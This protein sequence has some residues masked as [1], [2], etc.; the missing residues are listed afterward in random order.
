MERV[1][2]VGAGVAG[3]ATAFALGDAADVTVFEA[4]DVVSGR[5][6]TRRR[7]GC[8]Y[9]YGANYVRSD[10]VCVSALVTDTLDE[11]LVDIA[12]PVWTFGEDGDVRPGEDRDDCKWTW[13]GGIGRF[14][15]RLLTCSSATVE[16]ETPVDA[17][18]RDDG[19]WRLR[20]DGAFGSFNAVVLTPPAPQTAD[21][22]AMSEW[23]HSLRERLVK[24]AR[25]IPY[26]T[27]HSV[28]LHHPFELKRPWYALVNTDRE[29]EVGWLS[30]EECKSGHVPDG[31]T[32]LVVQMAPGWTADDDP[33]A[34]AAAATARLLGD[35]RLASPDWAD[36]HR[37]QYA[38]PEA[39]VDGGLI[40]SAEAHGI[41]CAGDWVAGEGRVHLAA[42]TGLEVGDRLSD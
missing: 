37:W 33:V 3:A 20:A 23:D 27:I 31:E 1:A 19:G 28:L 32:L 35:D 18:V 11:G 16:L 13:E 17:V 34:E 38:L 25:A 15:E 9:D 10:D 42:R 5:A 40:Q 4:H 21:L 2:I 7:A 8:I 30:R 6:A 29:H 22:L 24:A 41:Y 14:A 39:G 26:R 12:P 36:E